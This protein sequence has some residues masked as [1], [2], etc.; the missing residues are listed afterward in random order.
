[1]RSTV[2][3]LAVQSLL[4]A[5]L[6]GCDDEPIPLKDACQ[7][8][9][10]RS[11]CVDGAVCTNLSGSDANATGD[12]NRCL[13]LCDRDDD[14]AENEESDSDDHEG[15]DATPDFDVEDVAVECCA[16]VLLNCVGPETMML[17]GRRRTPNECADPAWTPLPPF[18]LYNGCLR[19]EDIFAA[20]FNCTLT[21][22]E[23]GCEICMPSGAPLACPNELP[24]DDAADD[25]GDVTDTAAS[26][27]P[28][29]FPETD[30]SGD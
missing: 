1:M 13:P 26:G 20:G 29:D 8:P 30:G 15:S 5:A 7:E 17:G 18:R 24:I 2:H 3:V 16:V 11:E 9:G 28:E 12:I 27:D 22:D 23:W 6:L 21:V 14:C 10:Q 25:A 19:A 4:L